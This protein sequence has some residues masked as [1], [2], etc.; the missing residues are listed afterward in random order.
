M[1][2]H[3]RK[4]TRAHPT[5]NAGIDTDIKDALSRR[6]ADL[7][8]QL[9]ALNSTM[10]EIQRQYSSRLKQLQAQKRPLE[11]ALLHVNAL[12]RFEDE[13]TVTGPG[14]GEASAAHDLVAEPSITEAAFNLLADLRQPVHYKDMTA[15]LQDQGVYIP[16]RDPAA[17]LLSR[18]SRD[19]RFRRTRKRGV[20]SLSTWRPRSARS[21]DA[22]VCDP[23][24]G[25]EELIPNGAPRRQPIPAIR[26]WEQVSLYAFGI[27]YGA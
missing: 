27:R 12:L 26:P 6:K 14:A 8:S 11:D 19:D 18:M 21:S 20:Y 3:R 7:T 17:T 22:A 10:S 9:Q 13:H 23:F 25:T 4:P 15:R 1:H 5:A 16:G 24:V 2:S